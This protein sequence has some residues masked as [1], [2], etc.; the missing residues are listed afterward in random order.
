MVHEWRRV[1]RCFIGGALPLQG[2][3]FED[4]I[5]QLELLGSHFKKARQCGEEALS[6]RKS[7]LQVDIGG[8][9]ESVQVCDQMSPG[10]KREKG[11][12]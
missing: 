2:T 8:I 1:V 12:C 5:G 3:N 11:G 9:S 7:E 4:C 6:T 10:A